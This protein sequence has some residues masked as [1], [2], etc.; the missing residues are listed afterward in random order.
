MEFFKEHDNDDG[1]DDDGEEA[2]EILNG[3]KCVILITKEKL[4]FLF[5]R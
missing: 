3:R 5:T 2:E 4:P 1:D